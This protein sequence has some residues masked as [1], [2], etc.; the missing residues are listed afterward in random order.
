MAF[1]ETGKG[2]FLIL[3]GRLFHVPA[4][5][6]PKIT[7][8]NAIGWC[9]SIPESRLSEIKRL[10]LEIAQLSFFNQRLD[11]YIEISEALSGRI[12]KLISDIA[13]SQRT[14]EYWIGLN[15]LTML[16]LLLSINPESRMAHQSAED[17]MLNKFISM[18]KAETGA[19]Q[20]IGVYAERL[21]ITENQLRQACLKASGRNPRQIIQKTTLVKAKK[22]PCRNQ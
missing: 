19:I 21:S 20:Q 16:L 6:K 2:S 10:H 22:T 14:S 4:K 17:H 1:L 3:P 7:D 12:N 9:I 11:P 18:I 8:I 5:S 13:S 15:S